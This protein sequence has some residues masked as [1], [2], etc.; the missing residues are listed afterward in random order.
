MTINE[1]Q[2]RMS[3]KP[4]FSDFEQI[5][6]QTVFE[7]IAEKSS[8]IKLAKMLVIAESVVPRGR[9]SLKAWAENLM[10]KKLG[11]AMENGYK[12]YKLARNIVCWSGTPDAHQIDE[13][14]FD[15]LGITDCLRASPIV[16]MALGLNSEREVLSKLC[17]ILRNKSVASRTERQLVSLLAEVRQ[18]VTAQ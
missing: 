12:A 6:R 9:G 11:S 14:T 17:A 1:L 3:A 13:K 18:S 16:S 5:W 4:N 15:S 7:I 2:Q 10:G 8:A